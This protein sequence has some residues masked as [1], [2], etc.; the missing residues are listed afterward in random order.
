MTVSGA[1]VDAMAS[2]EEFA[3][4]SSGVFELALVDCMLACMTLCISLG[5]RRLHPPN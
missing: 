3:M 1:E 5:E 2:V 4:D